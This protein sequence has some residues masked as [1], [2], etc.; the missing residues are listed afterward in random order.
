MWGTYCGGQSPHATVCLVRL[1]ASTG[2]KGGFFKQPHRLKKFNMAPARHCHACR[3]MS[4][5]LCQ[6]TCP[7]L[8]H[9]CP[10]L[11]KMPAHK[12]N[13]VSGVGRRVPRLKL[14]RALGDGRRVA[15]GG[16]LRKARQAGRKRGPSMVPIW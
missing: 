4:C 10:P 11:P 3:H 9:T 2:H 6:A 15:G 13:A 14:P 5:I 7:P 8:P 16:E 12:L 1:V